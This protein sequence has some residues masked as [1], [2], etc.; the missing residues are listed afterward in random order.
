VRFKARFLVQFINKFNL[1]GEI[2]LNGLP[3]QKGETGLT[4]MPGEVGKAGEY[5]MSINNSG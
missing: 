1:R 4:G 3:G 2:G 5:K